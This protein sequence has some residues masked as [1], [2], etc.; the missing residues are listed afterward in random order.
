MKVIVSPR[1]EAQIRR[2]REWWRQ[3]RDKAPDL[4]EQELAEALERLEHMASTL[5][6]WSLQLGHA[7][8]RYRMPKTRCHL[9][10]EVI[11][12]SGEVHVL[13]AGG[14]QRRRPT[15]LHLQDAP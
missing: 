4:F 11:D 15:R 7:I 8:R 1:A 9:Y 14:G 13:A 3:N 12:A 6:G 2:R 5:P 10:L